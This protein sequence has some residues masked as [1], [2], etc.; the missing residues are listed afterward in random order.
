MITPILVKSSKPQNKAELQGLN[1]MTMRAISSGI[2]VISH[3]RLRLMRSRK[4]EKMNRMRMVP[5]GTRIRAF[6][7]ERLSRK[8]IWGGG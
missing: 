2:K 3:P 8:K 4:R 7:M 6:L 5:C 1:F